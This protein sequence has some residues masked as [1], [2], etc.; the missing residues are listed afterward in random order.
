[1]GACSWGPLQR[2]PGA[3]GEGGAAQRRG[4]QREVRDNQYG[5][6][7]FAAHYCCFCRLVGHKD[8]GEERWVALQKESTLADG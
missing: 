6:Q 4:P 5:D 8:T 3:A 2:R 1:M 7:A